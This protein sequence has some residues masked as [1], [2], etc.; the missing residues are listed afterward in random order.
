MVVAGALRV[1]HLG[2]RRQPLPR[3][4]L[5]AGQRQHRPPAPQGG[6][7]DPGA[8][9]PAVHHRAAARQRPALRGGP[10][11]RRAGT[12]RAGEG[13]LHQRRRRRD[14]ERGPDG[15][16]AH[17]PAQGAHDVPQLPRQHG[18]RDPDDRRPAPLGQRRRR[19]R[20]RALL[21]ALRLPVAVLVGVGG[22]GVRA[23]AGAPRAGGRVRRPRHDRGAG[24]RDH[25]RYG[26]HPRPAGRLPGRRPRDLR[27]PRH[28]LRRR[29][30][31]GRLRPGRRVV[32]RRQVG[33]PAG[34]DR[35]RQ[36][37]QLRLRAARRRD[38]L[39]RDRR[40]V[41]RSGCSPAA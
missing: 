22:A 23:G 1:A 26:G 15:P 8:G 24:A 28:R 25:S 10:A 41:R 12:R 32:R 35:L 13:V 2:L 20:R 18:H 9:R 4:L 19:D 7:R 11:D 3:L 14:R 39:G 5:A 31:D 6:R 37:Q 38:H 33:R 16:A 21:R 29:R 17:R 27:P 30:G 36:G 40:D 34:P